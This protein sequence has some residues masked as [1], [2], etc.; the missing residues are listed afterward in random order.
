MIYPRLFDI[1]LLPIFFSLVTLVMM[2][3]GLMAST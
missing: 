1:V 3:N 2:K